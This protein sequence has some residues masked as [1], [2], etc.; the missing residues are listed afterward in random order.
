MAGEEGRQNWLEKVIAPLLSYRGDGEDGRS[1]SPDEA[2][3][4]AAH[5]AFKISTALG[6]IPGPIGFAAILPEVV[7]LTRLQINLIYRIARYYNRTETAN[8]EIVLLI[9]ANVM[10]VAGG[11]T[12]IRRAGTALVIRSANTGVVRALARKIGTHVIDTAVEKATGRWIPVV[13]APLFGYF[14]RSLTRKIGMEAKRVLSSRELTIE[15]R[16]S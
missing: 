16:P 6:L 14:S 3:D 2:I 7:A 4:E 5:R 12:L 8:T 11:E 9:L 15:P 13:T 10:G 1:Q